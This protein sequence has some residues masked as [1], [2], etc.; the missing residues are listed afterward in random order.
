M[1]QCGDGMGSSKKV[2]SKV[3]GDLAGMNVREVGR[4]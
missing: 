3:Q 4:I 2:P 1:G